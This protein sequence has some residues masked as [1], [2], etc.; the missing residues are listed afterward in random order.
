VA[1]F[2]APG[3]DR[4][5]TVEQIPPVIAG[6]GGRNGNASG[7]G[8]D[9]GRNR[10]PGAGPGS[11]P[12]GGPPRPGYMINLWDPERW[13]PEN[14]GQ[15]IATLARWET[16]HG[17]PLVAVSPDGGVVATALPRSSTVALW[18]ADEGQSLDEIETT[19][20][21]SALA[22]GPD[23]LLA[24]GGVGT[25]QLWD[26][27]SG[28]S[29]G[30][31]TP[32]HSVIRL[33]RFHPR[34]TLLASV[35]G[36]GATD[37]ELW[38]PDSQNLVA[39]LPAAEP[40]RSEPP[41]GV[42]DVA[43]SPDGRTL[44]ASSTHAAMTPA[45]AI[46]EPAALAQLSGFDSW[47]VALAL[48][49]DGLLAIGSGRGALW[50]W[51]TGHCA[52]T[53]QQARSAARPGDAA[54]P[55]SGVAPAAAGASATPTGAGPGPGGAPPGGRSTALAFDDENRLFVLDPD[56]FQ[57]WDRPPDGATAFRIAL[58]EVLGPGGGFLRTPL[59]ARTSDGRTVFLARQGQILV[60]Q[61]SEPDQLR[62][63]TVPSLPEPPGFERDGRRRP[64]PPGFERDGR[65]PA[66]PEFDRRG[67]RFWSPSWK[68]LAVAP[69]GAK[70]YL[71]D[72]W[73]R[74]HV[75]ALEADR[76]RGRWIN[77][78]L[79]IRATTLAVSPDGATLALDDRQRLGSVILVDTA[80][81][82]ETAQLAQASTET[83]GQII[84]LAFAPG[85]RELAVG[86]QQGL[87]D[88][89]SLDHRE[90]PR[91]H[92]PAHRGTVR[93]LAFDPQ[94]RYLAS[95]GTDRTV[96]VWDLGIIRQELGRLGLA[97]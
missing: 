59:L 50:F 25:I 96:E 73:D 70:L 67:R 40:D 65:G 16:T 71:I 39:V 55:A 78:S 17:P 35:G 97:W 90:A 29:L 63:L 89:W 61:A 37:I 77:W 88:V 31:I 45:W 6:R 52:S 12:D 30:Q 9:A 43:F 83:E 64:P 56:V 86:T 22:M 49:N 68:M 21:L 51:Q 42:D 62:P 54:A 19:G 5:V 87:I 41:H 14:I 33:L 32:R 48:R 18:S 74:V 84:T 91:I 53:L 2:A 47:P 13:A 79:P 8:G 94:G 60:W 10:G 76:T 72:N 69:D 75:L 58:P 80:L 46:V 23:S 3:G 81:G 4:L 28:A 7:A 82:V 44:V 92:L 26:I 1:L 15:P 95:G 85:G 38:D 36:M 93:A 24:T 57:C 66:A 20:E 34:G 27:D 11:G